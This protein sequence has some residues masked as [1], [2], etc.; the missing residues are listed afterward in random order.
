MLLCLGCARDSEVSLRAADL[1]AVRLT[2][3]AVGAPVCLMEWV[4]PGRRSLMS[5]AGARRQVRAVGRHTS[6]CTGLSLE[7]QRYPDSEGRAT[8]DT[9][10][11]PRADDRNLDR[12]LYIHAKVDSE[13]EFD[14]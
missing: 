8:V 4:S 14:L 9:P 5:H 3:A 10:P 13:F 11:H 2:T 12:P 6:M 1:D 7:C